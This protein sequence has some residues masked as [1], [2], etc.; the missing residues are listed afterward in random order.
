M[1][2]ITPFDAAMSVAVTVDVPLMTTFPSTTA[3]VILRP[4]TVAASARVTTVD[5]GT[6]P[7]ITWYV[8]TL[9]SSSL[10]ARSFSRSAAGILANAS[11]VGASTVNGPGPCNV[12]TRPAAVS[13]VAR[14]LN[15]PAA[16]AVA[17][18]S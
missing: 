9:V 3:I 2:W 14:V 15:V 6:L 11:S 1:T 8:R 18:M 16:T 10:L 12:S 7:A 5:D 13:A 4:S 17:T